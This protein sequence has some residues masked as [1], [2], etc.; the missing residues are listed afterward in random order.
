[1]RLCLYLLVPQTVSQKGCSAVEPLPHRQQVICCIVSVSIL[2][3]LQ[4]GSPINRPII[5]RCPL[6]GA[7]PVRIP[8]SIFSWCLPN[9]SSSSA[10]FLHGLPIISLPWLQPGAIFQVL[11]CWY[12]VQLLI[13]SLARHLGIPRAGSGPSSGV[14][15]VC[16]ACCWDVKLYV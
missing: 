12:L 15:D 13:A 3:N 4:D 8:T 14:A 10:L 11:E 2:Q 7:C 6:T 5:R 9:L 1:M 16:L